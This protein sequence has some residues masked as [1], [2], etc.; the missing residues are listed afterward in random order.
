[1]TRIDPKVDARLLKKWK[2]HDLWPKTREQETNI[3]G[4]GDEPHIYS[5]FCPEVSYE[6]FGIFASAMAR[7]ADEIDSGNAHEALGRQGAAADDWRWAWAQV[8][9]SHYSDCPLFAPLL[10]EN[11][12]TRVDKILS[13]AKNS[14]IISALIVAGIVLAAVAGAVTHVSTILSPFRREHVVIIATKVREGGK[15]FVQFA[16]KDSRQLVQRIV[17][18][19]PSDVYPERE[20]LAPPFKEDVEMSLLKMP[21]LLQAQIPDEKLH[22]PYDAWMVTDSVPVALTLNYFTSAGD[23]RTDK[24]L[25][26]MDFFYRVHQRCDNVGNCLHDPWQFGLSNIRYDRLLGRFEEPKSTVDAMLARK[27]FKFERY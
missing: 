13:W 1:A 3:M 24:L 23:F 17:L 5:R 10:H 14:P 26:E 4:P 25:Y 2:R 7:Y 20:T 15:T 27:H 9:P 11:K 8:T 6:T 18:D 21:G 19:F 12:E 16:P 22:E